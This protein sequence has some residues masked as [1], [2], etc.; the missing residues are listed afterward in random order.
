LSWFADRVDEG[1]TQTMEELREHG[2][3][4]LKVL[5][6]LFDPGWRAGADGQRPSPRSAGS[7]CW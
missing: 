2:V 6:D 3:E 7:M 4:A 1:A 5:V